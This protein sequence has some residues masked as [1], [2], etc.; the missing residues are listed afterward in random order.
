MLANK[1]QAA[2]KIVS[3]ASSGNVYIF[4][5][6][7]GTGANRIKAW[8]WSSATGFGTAFADPTT[9][10]AE[11]RDPI[12][13]PQG[14]AVI[15]GR[16]GGQAWQFSTTGWGAKYVDYIDTGSNG[17]AI[18]PSGNVIINAKGANPFIKAQPWSSVTGFGVEYATPSPILPGVTRSC[19]ISPQGNAVVV[20]WSTAS[21]NPYFHIYPWSNSTGFGAKYADPAT[22]LGVSDS[23][24]AK[25]S[26]AGDVIL[27][28]TSSSPGL[29]AYPFSA[30]TGIGVKYANPAVVPSNAISSVTWHPSG[31]AVAAAGSNT[32]QVHAYAW[33]AAGFGTKFANPTTFPPSAGQGIGCAFAP[34][35]QAIAIGLSTSPYIAAWGWSESGFGALY[36]NPSVLPVAIPM[37]GRAVAFGTIPT[38]PIRTDVNYSSVSLLLHMNGTNGSTTF[39]D[40]SANAFTVTPNGNTQISTA[41]SKFGGASGLFDG[42]GDYLT[43]PISSGLQFASSNF[44]IETWIRLSSYPSGGSLGTIFSS[45]VDGNNTGI[46]FLIFDSGR[47]QL[48]SGATGS[49][50]SGVS[51]IL[52]LNQW[53]HVAASVSGSTARVF[54]DG[55]KVGEST[56]WSCTNS[57]ESVAYVGTTNGS[58]WFVN[59]YMDDLRI[60]KGVA[61]YTVLN[62]TA[63]VY[64]YPDA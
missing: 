28:G 38:N 54:L 5:G 1:V 36:S 27:F 25:F 19:D 45:F 17:M 44:T 14:D 8:P 48:A 40:N 43:V 24:S 33:S 22:G 35:G 15:T 53:M 29:H 30:S 21:G 18:H 13:T 60:T 55:V 42:N 6:S 9:A 63:P 7:Q 10:G 58:A 64:P 49:I 51:N 31:N 11:P 37:T 59:G 39:T 56:N 57:T 41:Q 2:A 16:N 12:L 52:V 46:R 20:T 23:N 47:F 62:F 3:A 32:P 61:R 4:H 34:D 50:T 26:P